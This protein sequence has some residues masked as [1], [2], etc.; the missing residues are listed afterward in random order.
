VANIALRRNDL[1]PWHA[2]SPGGDPN[3]EFVLTV[4]NDLRPA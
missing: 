3:D 2:E 1:P 4:A